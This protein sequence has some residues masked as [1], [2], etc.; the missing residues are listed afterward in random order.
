M[1]PGIGEHT[2]GTH[3]ELIAGPETNVFP[4]DDGIDLTVYHDLID[5][6]WWEQRY[7]EVHEPPPSPSKPP[8]AMYVARDAEPWEATVERIKGTLAG[9]GS[10][11]E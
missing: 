3:A 6:C 5:G 9:D 7:G 4:L 11:V 2:D 8:R 10:R 1:I